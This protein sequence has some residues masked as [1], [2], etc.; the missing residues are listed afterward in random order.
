MLWEL[1]FGQLDTKTGLS[2]YLALILV[3]FIGLLLNIIENRYKLSGELNL[4]PG[5]SFILLASFIPETYFFSPALI[6]L[7]FFLLAYHEILGCYKQFQPA[8]QIFNIGFFISIAFLFYSS[9]WLFIPFALVALGIVRNFKFQ[10]VMMLI[11]GFITPLL[12]VGIFCFWNDCL[13]DFISIQFTGAVAWMSWVT[14]RNWVQLAP[15]AF[16]GGFMLFILIKFPSFQLKKGIQERKGID[17]LY[18]SMLFGGIAAIFQ[19]NL[20]LEHLL[21]ILPCLAYAL[22]FILLRLSSARAE[23]FHFVL[24]IM[25]ILWQFNPWI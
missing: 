10:E 13:E 8:T 23:A 6:A 20:N 21:L 25:V 2:F 19:P 17:V 7:G 9:F 3:V 18:W 24:F 1:F 22:S 11:V 12:L 5:A 4:L 16:F 14:T 15:L